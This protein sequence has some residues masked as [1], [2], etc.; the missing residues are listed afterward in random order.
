MKEEVI[1]EGYAPRRRPW[2][3][4]DWPSP[5]P[6]RISTTDVTSTSILKTTSEIHREPN[7]CVDEPERGDKQLVLYD[8]FGQYYSSLRAFLGFI[9][10]FDVRDT[11]TLHSLEEALKRFGD[12]PVIVICPE[13]VSMFMDTFRGEQ[14]VVFDNLF[15][16]MEEALAFGMRFVLTHEMGHHLYQVSDEDAPW[17]ECLANW[18]SYCLLGDRDRIP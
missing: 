2:L 17:A 3:T 8:N 13:R 4:E 5:W 18:F 7:S 1:H 11:Y 16:S 14:G 6:T 9:K 15:T 12:A 10:A